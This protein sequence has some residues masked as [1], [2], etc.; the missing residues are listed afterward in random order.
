MAPTSTQWLASGGAY[1]IMFGQT[2][3]VA[4]VSC[5]LALQVG[6]ASDAEND[7]CLLAIANLLLAICGAAVGFFLV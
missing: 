1:F 6:K 4:V 2:A 3:L 5:W 7:G